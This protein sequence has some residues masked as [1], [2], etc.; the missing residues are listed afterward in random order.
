MTSDERILQQNFPKTPGKLLADQLYIHDMSLKDLS[1]TMHMSL[2]KLRRI[3]FGLDPI[4]PKLAKQFEDL[5]RVRKAIWMW[6]QT[7]ADKGE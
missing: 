1:V 4:T 5:F 6:L 7:Q 2:Q 3:M